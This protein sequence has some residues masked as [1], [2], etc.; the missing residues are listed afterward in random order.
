[1]AGSS[2][3]GMDIRCMG[4]SIQNRTSQCSTQRRRA[5][6]AAVSC[7][8]FPDTCVSCAVS[9]GAWHQKL[10]VAPVVSNLVRRILDHPWW[11]DPHCLS[12]DHRGQ[13]R[14][15]P[16]D[17]RH[18]CSGSGIDERKATLSQRSDVRKPT[19]HNLRILNHDVVTQTSKNMGNAG[20]HLR[21]VV[22]RYE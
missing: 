14:A 12:V 1:M 8:Y 5:C 4:L 17:V 15:H 10:E 20:R 16:S 3:I 7:S 11:S 13:N 18:L 2:A 6:L 19:P 21:M 9:H 22:R